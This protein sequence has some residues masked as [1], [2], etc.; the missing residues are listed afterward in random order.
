[1][2]SSSTVEGNSSIEVYIIFILKQCECGEVADV[3]ITKSNK[4]NNHGRIYTTSAKGK[5]SHWCK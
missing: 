1:M 3:K 5:Y 4:N 2:V